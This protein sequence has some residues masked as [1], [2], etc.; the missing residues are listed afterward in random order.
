MPF[1]INK[2]YF[3]FKTPIYTVKK[4]CN[5]TAANLKFATSIY[6]Y[7]P[8]RTSKAQHRILRSFSIEQKANGKFTV[9]HIYLMIAILAFILV[10][11]IAINQYIVSI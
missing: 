5:F 6:H 4:R 3:P 11:F 10:G 9:D 7:M 8:F 1:I 2:T